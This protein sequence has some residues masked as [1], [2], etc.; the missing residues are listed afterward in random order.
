LGPKFTI[1]CGRLNNPKLITTLKGHKSP[2][3]LAT[4]IGIKGPKNLHVGPKSPKF[5]HL[6]S[7]FH[8]NMKATLK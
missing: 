2:N 7:F 6:M 8:A 4:W 1:T 3:L 5:P